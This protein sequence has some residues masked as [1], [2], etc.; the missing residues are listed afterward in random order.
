MELYREL[1][2]RAE[3]LQRIERDH[4]YYSKHLERLEELIKKLPSGSGFDGTWSVEYINRNGREGLK[5]RINF[6]FMDENGLYDAYR[7]LLFTVTP[8]LLHGFDLSIYHIPAK[9]AAN[10]KDYILDTLSDSLS[11]MI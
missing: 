11:S 8:S 9:H 4:P 6:S 2:M 5:L 10:Y 1:A 7:N 3:V